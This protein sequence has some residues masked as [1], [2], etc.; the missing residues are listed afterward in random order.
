MKT[1]DCGK[2]MTD[3]GFDSACITAASSPLVCYGGEQHKEMS[4]QRP[5]LQK[6]MSLLYSK[7]YYYAEDNGYYDVVMA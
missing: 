6:L 2:L 7:P 5:Q 1:A 4:Q 3:Y